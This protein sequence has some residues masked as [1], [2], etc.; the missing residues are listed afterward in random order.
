MLMSNENAQQTSTQKGQMTL[1][2]QRELHIRVL[3]ALPKDMLWEV[4]KGWIQNPKT[5]AKVLTEALM[6]SADLEK[7]LTDWQR[8]YGAFF[9]MGL[10]L[11]QVQIPQ[12]QPSFTR[13]IVVA[14]GLTPNRVFEVCQQHFSCWRYTEDL[15]ETTKGRN[16]REPVEHYAIWVRDR[17]EADEELNNLSAKQLKEKNVQ[18]IVL[19]ERLLLELK[20]WDETNQHLDVDNVTLCAGSRDSDGLVPSVAWYDIGRLEVREFFPR[21][22]SPTIRARAVVS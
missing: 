4:A 10:D 12:Q 21:N 3:A 19:L 20:Y 17:Q 22:T 16:D 6:P 8:F 11:S 14:Q 1:G 15:D 5:L 18:G 9:A 13:L 2:Q 7:F